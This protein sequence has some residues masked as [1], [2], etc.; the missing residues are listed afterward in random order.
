M[1]NSWVE[2]SK[3]AILNNLAQ[4]QKLVGSRVEIV[5][6]IKSNA[7]GH[8]M[9]EIARLLS[10]KVK[11]FGV[12]SLGE[13]LAL[14]K[15]GIKNNIFVLSYAPGRYLS[16][17]IKQGIEL[18][19]YD[20]NYAKIIS[21]VALKQRKE[22]KVHVKIDTGTSR[23][24]IAP[25]QAEF[26]I[27][28]IIMMPGL[29]VVGL[30]SHFADSENNP[31]YTKSQLKIFNNVVKDLEKNQIKISDKH[32]ACSAASLVEPQANFNLI[33]L[34][35]GLYG[36]WPSAKVKNIIQKKYPWFKLKPA[37]IWKTKIVQ[38]KTIPAG[39]KVGYGST[40]QAKKEMKI[41][42][43]A[44]GYW[45]GYDRKLSNTGF[46]QI[47]N[48]VCSVVGRICMNLMMVDVSKIKSVK[49]GDEAI[50]LG[51]KIPAEDLAKK[52]GTINYEV[53]TRINPLLPRMYIK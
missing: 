30:Y 21:Q 4:Y 11:R 39:A 43:L 48:A 46:V 3:S 47:K 23:I 26:F 15:L 6:V 31:N 25:S 33:R 36:L 16:D 40:Y 7:Y 44:A 32:F 14:K 19:V 53:V 17:G 51:N 1:Y 22:A 38:I 41:A 45:E 5:P 52:I 49:T 8:G 13:A 37:L 34:G 35:L 28:K 12:V 50:L 18:P 10:A 29:K 9:F 24:G 2:I 27:K 42:V 20:L